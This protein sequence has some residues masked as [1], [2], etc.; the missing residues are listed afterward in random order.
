MNKLLYILLFTLIS[1]CAT[2][3][4]GSNFTDSTNYPA[5]ITGIGDSPKYPLIAA[6]FKRGKL[7]TYAPGLVNISAG[8]SLNTSK[9]N[10]SS[11]IYQYPATT[12]LDE[13]LVIEKQRI[14]RFNS[15]AKF[16]TS[17]ERTLSKNGVNY[18]A[19]EVTLR[20]NANYSGKYQ[21]LFSQLVLWQH[22]DNFIKLRSTSPI[23]Q[24]EDTPAKNSELLNAVNWAF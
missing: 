12:T 8:Y 10:I 14:A 5:E 9:N 13:M 22:E 4:Q 19:L 11:T 20:Y 16:L 23:S 21:E 3:L 18:R 6:G 2:N 1:G 17:N 15:T 7:L 24:S